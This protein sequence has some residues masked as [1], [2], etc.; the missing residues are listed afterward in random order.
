[1]SDQGQ[2]KGMI[3]LP[4][5]TAISKLWP[6][7]QDHLHITLGYMPTVTTN[8]A[9]VLA[10]LVHDTAKAFGAVPVQLRG[11]A[12]FGDNSKVALVIPNP[13]LRALRN[14][15]ITRAL[16]AFPKIVDTWTY[17]NWRPHVTLGDAK[18]TP[19][20][21]TDTTFVCETIEI[22]LM[23]G[24]CYEVAFKEEDHDDADSRQKHSSVPEPRRAGR[25]DGKRPGR[26]GRDGRRRVLPR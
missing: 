17:P 6:G 2:Y 21:S 16:K 8:Q 25:V 5:P 19:R 11:Q 23:N 22:S 10:M 7:V 14:V 26:G 1:M 4:I 24:P 15:I 9:N 20:I 13:R 18:R 12:V 3:A